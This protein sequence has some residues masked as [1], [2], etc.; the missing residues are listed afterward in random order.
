MKKDGAL[1]FIE[2]VGLASSIVAAD[3][4]LKTA[5]V[6][7][8]GREISKGQGWVTIK[9]TGDVAAVQAAVNAART[10][11]AATDAVAHT[12]VIM[13]PAAGLG[14]VMVQNKETKQNDDKLEKGDTPLSCPVEEEKTPAEE[15]V[16]PEI[17]SEGQNDGV[18]SVSDEEPAAVELTENT[19]A[20]ENTE[21]PPAGE[22]T[23]NES[24][25]NKPEAPQKSNSGRHGKRKK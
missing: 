9:I 6:R 5:N 22:V 11:L 19:E 25:V 21:N 13:R 7:L 20:T 24:G 4:A 2:T 14:D 8:I 17:E 1:G 18:N 23:E 16:T 3:A 15:N 10:V 12:N